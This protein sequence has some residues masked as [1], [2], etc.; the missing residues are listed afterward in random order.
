MSELNK[1]FETLTEG[2]AEKFHICF[3]NEDCRFFL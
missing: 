2:P 3:L 1:T